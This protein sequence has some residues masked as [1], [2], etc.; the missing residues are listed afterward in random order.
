METY[1]KQTNVTKYACFCSA[2]ML[3]SKIVTQI[4]EN[5]SESS[6]CTNSC[7]KFV[8]SRFVNN[9]MTRDTVRKRYQWPRCPAYERAGGMLR[10]I[11]PLSGVPGH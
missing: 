9:E 3:T 6:G 2:T 8:S 5:H 1:K 10:Y 4:T 7:N 11:L